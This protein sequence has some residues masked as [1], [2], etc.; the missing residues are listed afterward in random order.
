MQ[1]WHH[2]A[3]ACPRWRN[4]LTDFERLRPRGRRLAHLEDPMA[5]QALRRLMSEVP[6][7][8]EPKSP[9]L[10][11][12]LCNDPIHDLDIANLARIRYQSQLCAPCYRFR[13]QGELEAETTA[14]IKK[15]AKEEIILELQE[16]SAEKKIKQVAAVL[17]VVLDWPVEEIEPFATQLYYLANN[18]PPDSS[19][20]ELDKLSH[21]EL[22]NKMRQ[23]KCD[24]TPGIFLPIM[25]EYLPRQA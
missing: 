4:A 7:V 20:L 11:C 25:G 21:Q 23:I 6:M 13:K 17:Q 5:M 8:F 10:H 12:D 24:P 18:P 15:R 22:R 19:V 14:E 1:S 3:L 9:E 16:L 2:F